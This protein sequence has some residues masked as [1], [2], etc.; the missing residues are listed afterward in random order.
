MNLKAILLTLGLST[1][2]ASAAN[3]QIFVPSAVANGTILGGIAGA[4]IGGHNHNSWGEGAVIG[5]AAGAVIGSAVADSQAQSRV[6]YAQP[7]YAYAYDG[8]PATAVAAD[9]PI[10]PAA[11]VANAAPVA[12][13]PQY[14]VSPAPQVVYVQQAPTYYYSDPYPYYYGYGYPAVSVGFGWGYGGYYRGGYYNR[15]GYYGGGHYAGGGGYRGG[16]R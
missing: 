5:A 14:V 12:T 8:A 4:L 3:A 2:A 7:Q 9:A 10:A 1:A 16:R 13:A 6:V 15:G 11:P